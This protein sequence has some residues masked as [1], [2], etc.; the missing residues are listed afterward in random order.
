M[1]P[2][3]VRRDGGEVRPAMC[4]LKAD[5]YLSFHLTHVWNAGPESEI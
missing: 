2:G 1:Q 5:D 3:S 4:R